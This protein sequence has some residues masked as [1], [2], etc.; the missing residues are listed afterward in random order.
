MRAL[1]L[2]LARQEGIKNFILRFRIFRETAFRFV[3]GETLQ[4]AL[5]AVREANRLGMRASLDL[6]GENVESGDD[7]RR[8]TQD[9]IEMLDAIQAEK[10]DCNVS[11]KLTQLGLDLDSEFCFQNLRQIINYAAGLGNFI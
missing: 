4:D 7:A 6:L 11:V 5:R 10:A 9:V 3:A 8:A 1:L 2:F